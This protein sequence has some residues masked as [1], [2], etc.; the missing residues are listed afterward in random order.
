MNNRP[1]GRR[2][3]ITGQGK[4]IRRRG[5]GLGTGPVGGAGRT[6][7]GFSGGSSG[8]GRRSGG[9]RS[10]GF[11][12]SKLIVLLLALLLGGG[13]GLGTLLSDSGTE[14]VIPPATQQTEAP[15]SSYETLL[16]SLGNLGGGSVSSGWDA[17]DNTQVLDNS[18][19][20]GARAKYTEL[21]G[22]GR[23]EV[24]VMV[25]LCGTDLESR[26]QMATKELQE[27]LDAKLGS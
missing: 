11:G 21:L 9:T 13:G 27:M 25:Y 18:V 7:G 3:N 15:V 4:N 19:A 12:G 10:G 1:T 26:S 16:G 6:P 2:K 14:V 20:P 5:A 24:T 22:G 8:G 23:D 17:Q